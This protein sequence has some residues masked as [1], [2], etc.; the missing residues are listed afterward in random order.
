M[1]RVV[2]KYAGVLIPA[3]GAP[4]NVGIQSPFAPPHVSQ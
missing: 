3:L 4:S 1:R 2:E